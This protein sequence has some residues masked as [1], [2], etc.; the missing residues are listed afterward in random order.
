[1]CQHNFYVSKADA[2]CWKKGVTGETGKKYIYFG[3]GVYKT[4][5]DE[6]YYIEN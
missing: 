2:F 1:M 4:D 5:Y 6:S 3:S